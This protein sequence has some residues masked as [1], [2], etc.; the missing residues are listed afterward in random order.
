M[1]VEKISET[2]HVYVGDKAIF[3]IVVSN[4]GE[5]DLGNV[6]VKEQIPDGLTYLSF[7][8]RNWN[9]VGDIFNYNGV[10]APGEKASFIIVFCSEKKEQKFPYII[11]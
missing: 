1:N 5:L 3:T 4:T 7:N 9:K 8:G 10:L 2:Q 6:F 11:I